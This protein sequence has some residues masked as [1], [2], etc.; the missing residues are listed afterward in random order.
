M[1]FDIN[2]INKILNNLG[3]I[4]SDDYEMTRAVFTYWISNFFWKSPSY[5][6]LSSY[7]ATKKLNMFTNCGDYSE[8]NFQKWYPSYEYDKYL[9]P[10]SLKEYK[11][12]SKKKI[13]K[14]AFELQEH[15]PMEYDKLVNLLI[16]FY[17]FEKEFSF[18]TLITRVFMVDQDLSLRMMIDKEVKNKMAA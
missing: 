9:D 15:I 3:D 10:N 2:K 6:R 17:Y 8:E 14:V 12:V 18:D 1:D 13:Q 11:K 4:D 7:D 5:E 16:R